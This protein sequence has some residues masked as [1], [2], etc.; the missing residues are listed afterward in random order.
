MAVLAGGFLWLQSGAGKSYLK[1]RLAAIAS[2]AT[3][4]QV[5]VDTLNTNFFSRAVFQGIVM[6]DTASGSHAEISRLTLDYSLFPIFRATIS[7]DS[8]LSDHMDIRLSR[9]TLQP[10]LAPRKPAEPASSSKGRWQLRAKFIRVRNVDIS[11]T[12]PEAG[13]RASLSSLTLQYVVGD[14]FSGE[15]G[16]IAIERRGNAVSGASLRV[17]GRRQATGWRLSDFRL[18]TARSFLS[19]NGNA[20]TRENPPGYEVDLKGHLAGDLFAFAETFLP[21][22]VAGKIRTPGIQLS[23]KLQTRGD[24]L[25]YTGSLST[26]QIVYDTLVFRNMQVDFAGTTDSVHISKLR[27]NFLSDRD[28]LRMRG[29]LHWRQK[30][31]AV[32]I[33]SFLSSTDNLRQEMG[34]AGVPFDSPVRL[35]LSGIIPYTDPAGITGA[36]ELTLQAPEYAGKTYAPVDVSTRVDRGNFTVMIRQHTPRQNQLQV[37]GK[38]DWPSRIAGSLRLEDFTEF[39]GSSQDTVPLRVLST[40]QGTLGAPDEPFQISGHLQSSLKQQSLPVELRA[41]FRVNQDSLTLIRGTLQ[42]GDLPPD[43]VAGQVTYRPALRARVQLSEPAGTGRQTGNQG[44]IILSV[45][46][47][48]KQ[49]YQ[50]KL[51]LT[52]V[53]LRRWASLFTED[54]I[55]IEGRLHSETT[56]RFGPDS[57]SGAGYLSLDSSRVGITVI[58]SLRMKYTVN[59]QGVRVRQGRANSKSLT[60]DIR[61]FLPFGSNQEIHMEVAGAHWPLRVANTFL[62]PDWYLDGTVSPS[63]TIDGTYSAPRLQGSV[64][65]DSG[66]VQWNPEKTPVENLTARIQLQGTRYTIDNLG[67]RYGSYPIDVTGRGSLAPDFDGT[68]AI[69]PGG[70]VHARYARASDSLS[71]RADRIPLDI[72]QSIV[73]QAIN[74]RGYSTFSIAGARILSPDRDLHSTGTITPRAGATDG[75][76]DLR[77]EIRIPGNRVDIRQLLATS[78][79]GRLVLSGRLPLSAAR[80]D[81][82]QPA[83]ADSMALSLEARAFPLQFINKI[84]SAVSVDSGAID[85]RAKFTGTLAMPQANG[86]IRVSGFGASSPVHTWQV[87]RGRAQLDFST[88]H[89]AIRELSSEMNGQPV[90]L[91]GDLQYGRRAPLVLDLRGTFADR[92]PIELHLYHDAAR[93][94]LSG[95]AE[96]TAV[97]VNELLRTA[98]M[99]R[100][101]HGEGRLAIHLDGTRAAPRLSLAAS[102][103]QLAFGK[104]TFP[105]ARIAAHYAAQQVVLDTLLLANTAQRIQG[106]GTVSA[107]LNLADFQVH[108]VG[109]EVALRLETQDFSLET[110]QILA[111]LQSNITGISNAEIRYSRQDTASSLR[112]FLEI[113]NFAGDMPYFQQRITQGQMRADFSGQTIRIS[114]ASAQVDN[115]SMTLTGNIGLTPNKPLQ[116]DLTLETQQI[117][118]KRPGELAIAVAPSRIRM[119]NRSEDTPVI[120]GEINLQS[121]KYTKPIYNLEPLSLIGV[122]TVKPPRLPEQALRNTRVN[123]DVRALRNTQI[124]NNLAQINFTAD[125]QIAGPLFQPRLTGR[126]LSEKGTIHYLNRTFTLDQGTILFEGTPNIDPSLNIQASTI[127]PAYQNIDNV[128][129]TITLHVSQ[130]LRSPHV[131]FTSTPSA[132]PKTN[133]ALTQSDIIGIL[134]VGRPREQFSSVAG[135]GNLSQFLLRQASQFSSEKIASLVEYRVGRLLDLDRVAI[136]GNLF[137]LSGPQ[138]PTFTAVKNITP[139]LTLTYSTAIGQANEQGIRLNYRLSPSW[140]LVTETT[141]QQGYG[142][143]VKYKIKFK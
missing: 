26:H 137:Q 41:A 143:D 34:L 104:I 110:L 18:T 109:E 87:A 111:D 136:E 127:V 35:R 81:T 77:W 114:R 132:R 69:H 22:E 56:L 89:I 84:T 37:Q 82:T 7:I 10:F 86:E 71:V 94:S 28:T 131:Q 11:Y 29:Y 32:D 70:V 119:T 122:R 78:D 61:G 83:A 16:S 142:V 134:A 92:S 39:I 42:A 52:N 97:P 6:A 25:S 1:T 74:T 23:G 47:I 9:R 141:Q 95:N 118:L 54:A 138:V 117:A 133:E 96:M 72:V 64:T 62:P 91:Q 73:P 68:I 106:T 19:A 4:Y 85:A 50:G 46:E 30:R 112:G 20:L 93:D 44:R 3:G 60:A 101:I 49:T 88:R 135:E 108:R 2:G 98:G 103:Q 120:S 55:R 58:D 107:D 51:Q 99:P 15:I 21:R 17:A 48:F 125:L 33:T 5:S 13:L 27:T 126:I 76:W 115:G 65:V 116:Y 66:F 57:V 24:L 59:S 113:A 63:T 100:D 8:L 14:T 80:T 105:A 43:S 79:S 140:Y 102:V 121:F 129:Y 40:F 31:A 139:R 45:S 124:D 38:V 130:T 90:S 123:L 128:D 75:Q 67:F 12:D 53:S 36:G